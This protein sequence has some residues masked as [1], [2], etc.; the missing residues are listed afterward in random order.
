MVLVIVH[1]LHRHVLDALCLVVPIFRASWT[2][3]F[4]VFILWFSLR[5]FIVS[6]LNT[7]ILHWALDFVWFQI[8]I[9]FWIFRDTAIASIFTPCF[10]PAAV[11]RARSVPISLA[12]TLC[13]HSCRYEFSLT[14]SSTLVPSEDILFAKISSA[15]KHHSGLSG[16]KSSR[17]LPPISAGA[18]IVSL[19]MVT[20]SFPAQMNL[21]TLL[22]SLSSIS[23]GI[24]C[25]VARY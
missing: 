3:S 10:F 8:I 11:M 20:L 5:H 12:V 9:S 15:T 7:H 13:V 14:L 18:Y 2:A 24:P 21:R 6:F 1:A 22:S 16:P 23:F 4:T 19:F 25:T 17:S